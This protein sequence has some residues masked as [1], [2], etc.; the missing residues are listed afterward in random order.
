MAGTAATEIRHLLDEAVARHRSGEL[1]AA[2][3]LYRE[4]LR[5]EPRNAGALSLLGVIHFQAGDRDGGLEHARRAAKLAPRAPGILNNLGNML[6]EIGGRAEAETCYRRAVQAEPRFGDGWVNLGRLLH[7]AGKRDEAGSCYRRALAI[8]PAYTGAHEHLALYALA[9]GN[10]DLARHHAQGVAEFEPNRDNRSLALTVAQRLMEAGR[11]EEASETL[12]APVRRLHG[13]G[14]DLR[15]QDGAPFEWVTPTKLLHDIEQM[16]YLR[17]RGLIPAAYDRAI[18][19]YRSVLEALP[20]LA[21]SGHRHRLGAAERTRLGPAYNRLLHMPRLPALAEGAINPALDF[22]A[23]EEHLRAEPQWPVVV[24]DF[25]SPPA[26]AALQRFCLEATVWWQFTFARELGSSIRNGFAAA[27]LLQVAGEARQRMAGVFGPHEP[28]IIWAYKYYENSSGLATH[29]DDGAVSINL[30]ITPDA[31]NRNPATGGLRFWSAA[32]P[33][34]YFA[35]ASQAEKV[36]ILQ[37]VLA[38]ERPPMR[39]IPYRCN[40]AL[41][42]RSNLLHQTNRMDFADGYENRRINITFLFGERRD[43]DAA[44]A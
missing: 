36:A 22:A 24:D 2:E 38:R 19:N 33:R 21:E 13:L 30:W 6:M 37:D 42:F 29:V 9:D 17:A 27:P 34:G 32:A 18:E 4:V 35:T 14:A 20:D 8:N 12:L 10:L 25:L 41:L 44:G 3:M 23:I 15:G 7:D 1:S 28:R 40:R 43:E 39:E 16:T 11:Y 26:L 5:R 31:A